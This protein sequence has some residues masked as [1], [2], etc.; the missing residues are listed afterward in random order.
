MITTTARQDS[1]TYLPPTDDADQVAS[2]HDFLAAHEEAGRGTVAPRY[3][4][5]GATV[6]DQVEIPED[7]HRVL[8]KVVDALR[9]GLAVTVAPQATKLTTQQA[10]D[11]LGITRP[12]VIKILDAGEIPFERVGTHRRLLLRDVLIYRE[13]RRSAQYDALDASMVDLRSEPALDAV[14]EDLRSARRAVAARR[15]TQSGD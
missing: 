11:L 4:L 12:T 14:L 9:N 7:I 2:I 5:A 6:G 10:A 15:A 1:E 3:F 13:R 8:L